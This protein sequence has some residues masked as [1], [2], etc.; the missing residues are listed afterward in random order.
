MSKKTNKYVNVA[1]AI[2]VKRTFSYKVP[3]KYRNK[4][5]VGKRVWVP[6]RNRKEIGYIVD[7][8]YSIKIPDK[9]L[10][11]IKEVIDEEPI[12]NR[13]LLNL[14]KQLSEYYYN[15][16]GE[17]IEA[18]IPP[19]LKKG[20]ISLTPRKKP[21]KIPPDEEFKEDFNLTSD[22]QK[23]FH[24]IKTNLDNLQYKVFLLHGITAS[25]KTEIYLQSIRE[26]RKR[27]RGCIVLVPEIS[28]TPQACERY[29]ARFVDDVVVLHSKMLNS[30]RFR[31]WEKVKN[32]EVSI[33]IGPRSAI[34]APVRNLGL[35]VVDE[36]Q[37]TT[38][39]QEDVPR[40]HARKVAKMRAKMNDSVVVLGSATPSIE[41]YYNAKERDYEL[42]YLPERINK[43]ELPMVE[44]VD[45]K[46]EI[47]RQR[48][49]RPV[50]SIFLQEG[51][52]K[53]LQNNQQALLFLN[54]KGFATYVH[55]IKCGYTCRCSRCNIAL[56][57][58]STQNK[59]LC[60]YCNYQEEVPEICPECNSSYIR[61][62][63]KGT[64]KVVSEIKKYFPEARVDR[65]DTDATVK[66]GSHRQILSK[67]KNQQTDI[68][69][70]T[71]MI[72]KGLDFPKVTLVGVISADIGLNLP[73]F[74]ACE[75]T[76]S[77]L[78]QV[79]GRAGR[80]DKGGKVVIQTFNPEHYSV[81]ASQYH[82]YKR[83]YKEEIKTREKIGFPPFSHLV[84]IT[85]RSKKK[86]KA[87]EVADKLAGMLEDNIEEERIELLGPAPAPLS[88]IKG[89]YRFNVILKSKQIDDIIK[90]MGKTIGHKRRIRN[91]YLKVDVDPQMIM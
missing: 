73:D 90:L 39:K 64:E 52:K 4:I 62:Y 15:S 41:S 26:A 80:G 78:T 51:L 11:S 17:A 82:D 21:E 29:T 58:H 84:N 8:L 45:M 1:V 44:I 27:G 61:K 12:V 30:H 81:T 63:G 79:A 37:E 19:G 23:A 83:F 87:A 68:L 77:L 57:Y 32:G 40:Y 7:I 5:S 69:I 67:F 60:H 66:R 28:L 36:E 18:T 42:L 35:I 3:K 65:M 22:Q 47:R 49:R 10:K 85:L 16:W 2:P 48:R 86:S 33:V 72:A 74:R 70:G 88:K 54:R 71:Q 46:E 43:K 76:F 55:C 6:F 75:R 91:V 50:L 13:E 59:L 38:Y 25:G 14:T 24:E 34:F 89:K 20:K 31:E 53:I 56:T 9:K